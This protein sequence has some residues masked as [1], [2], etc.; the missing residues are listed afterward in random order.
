V[1]PTSTVILASRNRGKAREFERLLESAFHVSPLPSEVELPE[2]TGR[3]FAE[4]ARLKAEAV[5]AAL[6][7]TSAV[8]ADDSGL[9][10][11]ALGGCPGV[12]SARYAG[13]TATDEDNVNKL[14]GELAGESAREARFV[15]ALCLVLPGGTDAASGAP[16]RIEVGGF[17]EGTIAAAPRGTDGFGYDP[18]F[19]P[20]GWTI[21]LAEA[22]PR[23]KDVV[24]HRGAAARALLERLAPAKEG[25]GGS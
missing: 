12:F 3:N 24:S 4:N 13:E 18:V 17:S 19:Q 15:C 21:T 20:A 1:T 9:E 14:L 23:A 25:H 11:A 2:E 10:V 8:L 22:D 7:G 6:G 5:F 16:R